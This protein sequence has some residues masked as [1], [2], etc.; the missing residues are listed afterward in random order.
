MPPRPA[1]P[2]RARRV[3]PRWRCRWCR[4]N[5]ERNLLMDANGLRV[6]QI[7]DAGG[8][9]GQHDG[10]AL[11]WRADTCTLCLDREHPPPVLTENATFATTMALKPSPVRDP[12]GSYAWWDGTAGTLRAGGFAPGSVPIPI[13]PDTPPG[14]PQ[15]TDLAF[16][17][18]DV[19]YVARN[20]G[21]VM[22]DR[23]DRWLPARVDLT[24]FQ[25][26][27]LAPVAG[28]GV[29]ALDRVG[30][31]LARLSGY[32]LRTGAITDDS[33]EAFHPK[34][35]NPRPPRLRR[36]RN[37]M[38]PAEVEPVAIAASPDGQ[39]AVLVWRAGADAELFTLDE[40][41]LVRRFALAGLRFPYGLA[42]VGETRV[43][44]IA[45]DG[46]GPAVQAFVYELDSPDPAPPTGEV[47]RLLGV[48]H[49]GFCNVLAEVPEY[50]LAGIDADTP[51]GLRKLHPL[52]RATY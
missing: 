30:R 26:H 35:P 40:A 45:S 24:G 7:A 31:R 38:L 10:R 28:G 9:A 39:V 33:G 25:A 5:A 17:T 41:R 19:L 50:P 13:P 14:V 1:C 4:K 23:R 46:A 48:W 47:F 34:E 20:D 51:V 11:R 18:D 52:S 15:P 12:G 49:G 3:S 6:W 21:V 16:G 36:Y 8:F 27:R 2:R 22:L 43:A 37:A 44:V 42:W 32:P 29:W